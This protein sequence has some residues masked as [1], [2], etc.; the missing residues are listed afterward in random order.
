MWSNEEIPWAVV[1]AFAARMWALTDLGFA[2]GYS[3]TFVSPSGTELRVSLHVD[4]MAI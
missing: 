1:Q 3:L 2:P 4:G